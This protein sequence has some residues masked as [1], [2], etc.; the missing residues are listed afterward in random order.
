MQPDPFVCH[1]S[2]VF[3]RSASD[4]GHKG[5]IEFRRLATFKRQKPANAMGASVRLVDTGFAASLP[6][7]RIRRRSA[8]RRHWRFSIAA[9]TE[10]L[11]TFRS[12]KRIILS[13]GQPPAECCPRFAE[14]SDEAP[15]PSS[16]L[17]LLIAR[18][19]RQLVVGSSLHPGATVLVIN[20]PLPTVWARATHA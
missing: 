10:A 9:E 3:A 11:A 20:A 8:R 7:I 4:P 19:P 15:S 1:V 17:L 6:S 18:L 2:H 16:G 13:T 14:N 12:W 5:T